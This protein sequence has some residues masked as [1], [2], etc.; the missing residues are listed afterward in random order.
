MLAGS[1]DQGN[2]AYGLIVEADDVVGDVAGGLSVVSVIELPRA[3][4]LQV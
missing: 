3:R 4:H 2:F 1:V